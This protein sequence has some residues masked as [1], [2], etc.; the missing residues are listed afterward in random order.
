MNNIPYITIQNF[1][2][3]EDQLLN[4]DLLPTDEL[5][6]IADNIRAEKGFEDEAVNP[7][8]DVWYNF[9]LDVDIV[10]QTVRIWFSC[11]NGE[12][13]DYANYEIPMTDSEKEQFLWKAFRQFAKEMDSELELPMENQCP[14]HCV[15]DCKQT[16]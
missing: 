11:N 9:Y 8:N 13:D 3:V 10:K 1:E 15:D 12:K 6:S 4:F 16:M 14:Y 2:W 5:I 7:N